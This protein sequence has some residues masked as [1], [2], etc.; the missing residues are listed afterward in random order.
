MKSLK[1]ITEGVVV[2]SDFKLDRGGRKYKAH[3]KTMNPMA[4]DIARGMRKGPQS[5]IGE[6]SNP[7]V[8]EEGDYPHVGTGRS[9]N[10][11]MARDIAT[12]NAKTSLLRSIHGDNFQDKP[13]PDYEED[14]LD[15]KADDKGNYN[16][17]VK[18]RQKA[19]AVKEDSNPYNNL[20]LQEQSKNHIQGQFIN[21]DDWYV[22]HDKTKKIVGS[23]GAKSF[24][25]KALSQKGGWGARSVKVDDDHTAYRGMTL[26]SV[27][28]EEYDQ[29]DEV[30]KKT[31]AGYISGAAKDVGY[32]ANLTGFVAGQKKPKGYNPTEESPKE[33]KRH[34]GITRALKK[35]VKEG[36]ADDPFAEL[37]REIEN[38]RN[39]KPQPQVTRREKPDEFDKAMME[40]TNK[41]PKDAVYIVNGRKVDRETY[42]KAREAHL[43]KAKNP[44]ELEM[45]D[46]MERMR[47]KARSR[48]KNSAVKEEVEQVDEIALKPEHKAAVR[49]LRPSGAHSKTSFELDSG[50]QYHVTREGDK[51]YFVTH[52]IGAG[53]SKKTTMNYKQ[54]DED[55][56]QISEIS[57][58]TATSYAR[59]KLSQ[60]GKRSGDV[61]PK[62]IDNLS[63][64]YKRMGVSDE[65]MKEKE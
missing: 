37:D 51:V 1:E 63:R 12:M 25:A 35:L 17:T 29:V 27:M 26:K 13:M 5:E 48:Q 52:E 38:K 3:R 64:A 4:M 16:A 57:K 43:D 28:R 58:A 7:Y 54:F 59:K 55:V 60:M 30:S 10:M 39:P 45:D 9:K 18:M 65:A 49:R 23:H 53:R 31:L 19:A 32:H 24:P 40:P 21:D 34:A 62:D 50:K 2:M 6:Q 47:A 42:D 61:T 20:F 14:K 8:N 41:D 33:L 44:R 22:V 11:Q 36:L 46:E 56:E 15:L